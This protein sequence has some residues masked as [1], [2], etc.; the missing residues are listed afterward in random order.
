MENDLMF[1]SF[2]NTIVHCRVFKPNIMIRYRA[3]IVIYPDFLIPQNAYWHLASFL[4]DKGYVVVVANWGAGFDYDGEDLILCQNKDLLR[5][6]ETLKQSYP[7]IPYFIIGHG[8]ASL[9]IRSFLLDHS[10][11]LDGVVLVSSP[12][13]P[14]HP[15]RLS[16]LLRG[17]P[18][19][20]GRYLVEKRLWSNKSG[21]TSTAFQ[22]MHS[23][24]YLS[25]LSLQQLLYRRYPDQALPMMVI[26]SVQEPWIH[27]GKDVVSMSEA[28]RKHGFTDVKSALVDAVRFCLLEQDEVK[29]LIKSWLDEHTYM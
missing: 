17:L 26:G 8:F 27:Y 3:V 13:R 1:T 14:R 18:Y 16:L 5:L 25:L 12:L 19:R 7:D 28:Y 24:R 9:F 2:F 22:I 11:Y 23:W 4:S 15:Y 21:R 10:D 20:K 6:S 29:E